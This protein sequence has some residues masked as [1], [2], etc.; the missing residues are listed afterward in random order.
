MGLDIHTLP[1]EHESKNNMF[2]SVCMSF[3]NNTQRSKTF[4]IQ[5]YNS[6]NDGNKMLRNS[7]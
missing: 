3:Y 2:S 1:Y 6:L 4:A 7:L 5:K